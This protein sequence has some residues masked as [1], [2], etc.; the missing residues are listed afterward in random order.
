MN[1]VEY[2]KWNLD[3]GDKPRHR[4]HPEFSSA[5][6]NF[7]L[8]V[9]GLTIIV[10]FCCAMLVIM[11]LTFVMI[12]HPILIPIFLVVVVVL[13]PYA[14]FRVTKYKKVNDLK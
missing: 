7:T 12:W 6:E 9:I 4:R 5:F 11:L 14:I 3:E 13:I 1:F 8:F 10:L 2:L